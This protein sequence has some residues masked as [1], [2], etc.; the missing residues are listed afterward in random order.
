M[1]SATTLSNGNLTMTGPVAD[2]NTS[3]R[4]LGQKS[5][6]RFYAEAVLDAGDDGCL[7]VQAASTAT[8]NSAAAVMYCNVQS[9]GT[10]GVRNYSAS[11]AYGA[12]YSNAPHFT[13]G[14][15]M[16]AVDLGASKVW[17]GYNGAWFGSGT[18]NPATAASPC[19]PSPS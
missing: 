6:G 2:S 11:N 12:L 9:D 14:T 15:A 13:G 5:S 18:Q 3:G 16:M 8:G 19:R 10:A 17:F 7:G 1:T 4:A